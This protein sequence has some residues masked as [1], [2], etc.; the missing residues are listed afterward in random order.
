MSRIRS[1]KPEFPQSESMGNVSRDSRGH[2][3]KRSIPAKIRRDLAQKHGCSPGSSVK[4]P[5]AYCGFVGDIHWTVQPTDRGPGWVSFVGLEMDHV[6]A[7]L[8]NGDATIENIVLACLPC[9]RSKGA[10]SLAQWKGRA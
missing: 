4:T 8:S 1:I 5:C 2:F 3:K 10:K 7:E 6:I 9:N